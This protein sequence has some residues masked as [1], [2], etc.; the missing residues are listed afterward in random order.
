MTWL[1]DNS[2]AVQAVA[3]IVLVLITVWYVVVTRSLAVQ[4]KRQADAAKEGLDRAFEDGL[5][6]QAL[7]VKRQAIDR[8]RA[9]L[10]NLLSESVSYLRDAYSTLDSIYDGKGGF[11][12]VADT[13]SRGL[14]DSYVERFLSVSE[15]ARADLDL[16]Y[17]GDFDRV[18]PLSDGL[19]RCFRDAGEN[20]GMDWNWARLH[21]TQAM[22]RGEVPGNAETAKMLQC[23]DEALETIVVL[24]ELRTQV[25][26]TGFARAFGEL[27]LDSGDLLGEADYLVAGDQGWALRSPLPAVFEHRESDPVPRV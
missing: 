5:R 12:E 22:D 23:M 17:L 15:E 6:Q 25:Q 3:T 27:D 19:L 8:A 7:L 18:F 11:P 24:K 21:A 13:K 14:R 1:Q 10:V 16:A 20:L 2:G 9:E 4:A 26:R